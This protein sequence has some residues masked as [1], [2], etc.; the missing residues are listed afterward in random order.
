MSYQMFSATSPSF[1]LLSGPRLRPKSSEASARQTRLRH[2]D[3]CVSFGT[4]GRS[5]IG[6]SRGWSHSQ[7]NTPGRAGKAAGSRRSLSPREGAGNRP[8]ARQARA[9]ATLSRDRKVEQYFTHNSRTQTSRRKQWRV[10]SGSSCSRGTI[11]CRGPGAPLSSRPSITNQL[12][13]DSWRTSR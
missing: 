9:S 7:A 6:I 10:C 5:W 11:C 3:S 1:S 4:T 13:I 12:P 8:S 2:I